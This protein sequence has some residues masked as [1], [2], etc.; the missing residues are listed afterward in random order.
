V[1]PTFTRGSAPIK[2]ETHLLQTSLD[3]YGEE[4]EVDFIAHLREEKKFA[5]IDELRSQIAQDIVKAKD[6][7]QI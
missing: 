1:N 5:S 7:L 4:I 6:I 2:V 3:A